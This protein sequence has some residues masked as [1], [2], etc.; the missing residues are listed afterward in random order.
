MRNVIC[1]SDG[2]RKEP[3]VEKEHVRARDKRKEQRHADSADAPK[4][5]TNRRAETE[6][7]GSGINPFGPV[8]ERRRAAYEWLSNL[9]PDLS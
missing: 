5:Q 7:G 4:N 3:M 2:E 9:V 8:V 6:I 1:G